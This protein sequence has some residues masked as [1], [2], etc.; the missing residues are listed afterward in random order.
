MLPV[1]PQLVRAVTHLDVSTKNV[2]VAKAAIMTCAS[3]G[4]PIQ[5]GN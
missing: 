2:D 3:N 1:S 5:S 4:S